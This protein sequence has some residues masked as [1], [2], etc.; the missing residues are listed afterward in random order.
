V[1]TFKGTLVK[2]GTLA[3][4]PPY[5]TSRHHGLRQ[6]LG[7][8]FCVERGALEVMNLGT[9]RAGVG[10]RAATRVCCFARPTNGLQ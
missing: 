8:L 4:C 1:P 9:N 5:D 6:Q 7:D 2:V 10:I 3:L